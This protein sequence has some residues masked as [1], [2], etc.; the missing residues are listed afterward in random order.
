MLQTTYKHASSV[1]VRQVHKRGF[2]SGFHVTRHCFRQ[3]AGT[4]FIPS[5]SL[6]SFTEISKKDLSKDLDVLDA[7]VVLGGGLRVSKNMI[8]GEIP[9]W[10]TRRLDGAAQLW[11][12]CNAQGNSNIKIAIS[13]GGS[14]HGLPVIHPET[15]QVVHEGTA[16]AEYLKHEHSVPISRILKESSSYDTVG[17]GYFSAM[18]H[19]V[20][21]EWKRI[22]VVTSEF[23]MPRSK[24]IF[25]KVYSLVN[26]S[27]YSSNEDD[28]IKLTFA[29]VKDEGIFNDSNVLK[30]R[31][32]KE[33]QSIVT[34]ERNMESIDTLRDFHE[35]FHATHICYSCSRQ[36]EFGIQNESDSMLKETY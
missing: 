23:H 12:M 4:T 2:L 13:G 5:S 22:A 10:A 33:S 7:I 20:P 15:G 19:A 21:S 35:W 24:A 29:A 27:L 32:E 14:P 3:V 34:W 6:S 31:N 36:L 26:E 25:E 1:G 16:Y 9:P 28:R 17:N 18:I 11:S 8:L 30:V